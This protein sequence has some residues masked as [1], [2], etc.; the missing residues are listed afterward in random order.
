M[1]NNK[2]LFTFLLVFVI[3]IQLRFVYSPARNR[4]GSLDRL[5]GVKKSE[6]SELQKLS[7]EYADQENRQKEDAGKITKG[8]FSL[9]SYAGGLLAKHNLEKNVAGIQPLPVS[10]KEGF[11]IERLKVSLKNIQLKQLYNFLY[12][13]ENSGNAIRIPD[14]R[15]RR[16][17]EN[18]Y[19][20][21]TEIEL[22]VL[23]TES[24]T[25]SP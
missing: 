8:G 24:P 13:V 22:V 2:R 10:E 3:I 1:M 5:L 25:L 17:K 15:M 12:D 9:F 11:R 21:D 4:L 6:L 20:L 14:F 16:D 18:P 23:K 7:A 19:L